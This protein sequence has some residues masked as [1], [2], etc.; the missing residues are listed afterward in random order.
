MD[1]MFLLSE[2]GLLLDLLS[3]IFRISQLLWVDSKYNYSLALV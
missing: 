2:F 3:T 1:Y